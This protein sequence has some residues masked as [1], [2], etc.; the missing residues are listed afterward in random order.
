MKPNLITFHKHV[1]HSQ[2]SYQPHSSTVFVEQIQIIIPG[3]HAVHFGLLWD[4]I[5][6]CSVV[7]TKKVDKTRWWNMVRFSGQDRHENPI[8]SISTVAWKQD[9][10]YFWFSR[11]L[12]YNAEKSNSLSWEPDS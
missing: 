2:K 1:V 3:T 9:L 11:R 10:L 7:L 6:V 8:S 12:G 5:L 4:I